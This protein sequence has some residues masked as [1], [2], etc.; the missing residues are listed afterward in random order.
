MGSI[1]APAGEPASLNIEDLSG[2]SLG[3]SPRLRGNL[4]QGPATT[5]LR[6]R[7]VYPRA[8]GGTLCPQV[9][10]DRIFYH[11]GLSPRL[12]GNRLDVRHD[13]VFKHSGLS[14]RLRGNPR[15]PVI[16]GRHASAVYPRACGGT[17]S[18]GS[19]AITAGFPTKVYPRACGGTPCEKSPRLGAPSIRIDGSIPAPAGEPPLA[20]M[21]LQRASD[22]AVYPRA[23]GG[24]DCFS[25]GQM[26]RRPGLSPRLR[27]N[28]AWAAIRAR[29]HV[30]GLSPR[31]RGNRTCW[32][33]MRQLVKLRSIPAPAGEPGPSRPGQVRL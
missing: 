33:P 15:H 3:L 11:A 31:L 16:G 20:Q 9:S 6:E 29:A 7:R 13:P 1:P 23:C 19:S 5:D 21:T 4:Q 8:C 2:Q 30:Q 27:G 17:Q 14:P 12:R 22:T 24:T 32:P 10:R 18:V 26:S 25:R 28:P